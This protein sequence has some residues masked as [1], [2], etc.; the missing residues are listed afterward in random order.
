[1]HMTLQHRFVEF[2]PESIQEGVLYISLEYCTAIHKCVCGCGNEVVTPISPNDW[3]FTFNGKSVSL[4][5]SIGNWSFECQ[6]HYWITNNR[7][8]FAGRWTKDKIQQGRENDLAVKDRYF[9]AE[10]KET[11]EKPQPAKRTFWDKIVNFFS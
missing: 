1:M 10:V 5:P 3:K 4:Y 8:E 11:T 9:S 6:S 2:I 7:I